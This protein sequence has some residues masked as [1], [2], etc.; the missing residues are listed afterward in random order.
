[1]IAAIVDGDALLQV[2]WVSLVAG[3][4]LTLVFSLAIAAGAR[5]GSARRAGAGGA[6]LGWYALTGICCLLCAVAVVLG[7]AVMLSK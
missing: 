7:V 6:A 5:A 3:I 4:G 1:M 2:V